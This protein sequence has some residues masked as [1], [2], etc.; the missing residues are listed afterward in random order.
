M[1]AAYR[2]CN[3]KLH[4]LRC[5]CCLLTQASGVTTLGRCWKRRFPTCSR[6]KWCSQQWRGGGE[7]MP[8]RGVGRGIPKRAFTG[9]PGN[10]PRFGQSHG[11]FVTKI[12]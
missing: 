5:D 9:N 8:R 4:F 2:L 10:I 7:K 1:K 6:H 12:T 3:L 11:G